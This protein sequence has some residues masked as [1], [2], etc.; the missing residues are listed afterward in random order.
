MFHISGFKFISVII[1]MSLENVMP[2]VFA[3]FDVQLKFKSLLSLAFV[4]RIG[5]I[6]R[7]VHLS[8]FK[9]SPD[10][11]ENESRVLINVLNEF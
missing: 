2:K 10:I 11:F 1:A 8:L 4:C 7:I 5:P 6:R 9:F 3:S